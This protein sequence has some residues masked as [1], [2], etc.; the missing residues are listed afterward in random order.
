VE[1]IMKAI[2]C[3]ALVATSALTMGFAANAAPTLTTPEM[4]QQGTVEKRR[5]QCDT[6]AQIANNP[7]CWKV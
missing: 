3:A 5:H 6:P 1:T 2:L 7:I 4:S